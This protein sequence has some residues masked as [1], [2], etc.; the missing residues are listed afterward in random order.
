MDSADTMDQVQTASIHDEL[1]GHAGH[2]GARER[3]ENGVATAERVNG[4][5]LLQSTLPGVST[6]LAD[7]PAEAPARAPAQAIEVERVPARPKF[8]GEALTFDDV[9]LVPGRSDVLPHDVDTS[10][11]LTRRIHL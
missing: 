6:A 11:R 10:T 8:L 4:A 5:S 2:G 3:H 9:L 1:D 7:R